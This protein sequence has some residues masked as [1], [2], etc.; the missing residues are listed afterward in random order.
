VKGVDPAQGQVFDSQEFATN[1]AVQGLG[2][3]IG[4][5]MLVKEDIAARRLMVPLDLFVETGYRYY[6]VCPED[7][8]QTHKITQFREWLRL[9]QLKG[10]KVD[11][12]APK[13][14]RSLAPA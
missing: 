14:H 6:F 13:R 7:M 9:R 1:A 2:V 8:A 4:D 5:C 3:G 11:N 10:D 12:M